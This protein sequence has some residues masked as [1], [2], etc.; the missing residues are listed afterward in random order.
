M[1]KTFL[2]FPICI[3]L[4]TSVVY[5]DWVETLNKSKGQKV[6]FN[7]WGGSEEIN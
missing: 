4:M 1:I 2:I 6:F 7:A 5:A 3:I